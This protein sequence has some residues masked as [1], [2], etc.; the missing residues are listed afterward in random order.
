MTA[1]GEGVSRGPSGHTHLVDALQRATNPAFEIVICGRRE[2][3]GTQRLLDT[4]RTAAPS[5]SSILLIEPDPAGKTIR[6][7]APFTENH[8]MIEGKP[9]A[10]VCRNHQC[11]MPTT[12]VE[13]LVR[14]LKGER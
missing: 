12:D 9:T 6:T 13:A 8:L 5:R 14:Q 3:P 11:Q 7:L 4:V 10:Y 1:F 2:N